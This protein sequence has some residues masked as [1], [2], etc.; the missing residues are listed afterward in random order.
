VYVYLEQQPNTD[1]GDQRGRGS[2]SSLGP[3]SCLYSPYVLEG[4]FSEGRRELPGYLTRAV[5][6]SVV[7]E[8]PTSGSFCVKYIKI[9]VPTPTTM[10]ANSTLSKL[11]V[12]AHCRSA[13]TIGVTAA[14]INFSDARKPVGLLRKKYTNIAVMKPVMATESPGV[15]NSLVLIQEPSA[16]SNGMAAASTGFITLFTVFLLLFA[17]FLCPS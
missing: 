13:L 16:A 3:S 12:T 5:A 7:A 15:L 11:P 4:A 9:E 14:T 8:L 17:I 1:A 10:V 6:G 2:L